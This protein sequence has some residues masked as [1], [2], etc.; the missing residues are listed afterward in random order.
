MKEILIGEKVAL[1]AYETTLKKKL[2]PKIREM[3]ARQHAEV[4]RVVEQVHLLRGKEGKRLM[5]RLFNVAKDAE[6]AAQGLGNAGFHLEAIERMRLDAIELYQGRGSTVLETSASGAVGGALWGSLIGALA[7][8]GAE[9]TA[10]LVPLGAAPVQDIWTLVA[11]GGILA[12]AFGG[13][14]LGLVIGIGISEE[15]AY[16]YDESMKHG[17]IILIVPVEVARASEAGRIMTQVDI[18]SGVRPEEA[19]AVSLPD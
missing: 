5:V 1:R 4:R 11:L 10:S 16:L 14:M 6:D 2:P 19:L 12:G 13:A 9:Q 3:V 7:G 17:Q 15:N 18:E 8:I